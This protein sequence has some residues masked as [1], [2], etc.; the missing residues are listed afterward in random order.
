M[1][2]PPSG[3]GWQTR[4]A[5]CESPAPSFNSASNRPA[6]PRKSTLRNEGLAELVSDP[7]KTDVE[8]IPRAILRRLHMAARCGSHSKLRLG[9][10]LPKQ[11]AASGSVTMGFGMRSGLRIADYDILAALC[12]RFRRSIRFALPV[13][14]AKLNLLP[15]P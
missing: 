13:S 14:F 3:C 6:G 10:H 15:I 9:P 5:N 8:V 12:T 11:S 2:P 7:D 1:V 4:P